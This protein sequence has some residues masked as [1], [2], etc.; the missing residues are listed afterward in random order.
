[1]MSYLCNDGEAGID[2]GRLVDVKYEVWILDQINPEPQRE[3]GGERGGEG[4]RGGR[5]R[6]GRE[7]RQIILSIIDV[8]LFHARCIR[9][10]PL[11]RGVLYSECPLSEVPQYDVVTC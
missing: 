5:E 4:E 3:T 8:V 11:Y 9:K 7:G 10:C 6:R 2:G 1:M